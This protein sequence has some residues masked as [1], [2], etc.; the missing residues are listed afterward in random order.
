MS[1]AQLQDRWLVACWSGDSKQFVRNRKVNTSHLESGALKLI[2][3]EYKKPSLTKSL[4]H[5][6]HKNLITLLII[7][8][9]Q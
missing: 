8:A 3:K 4:L 6:S 9:T 2:S 5:T 7:P 1:C